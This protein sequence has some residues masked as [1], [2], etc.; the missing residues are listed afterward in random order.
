MVMNL[1]KYP[2]NINKNY[3]KLKNYANRGMTLEHEINVTNK[4]Y[5]ENNIAV[6]HKKPTPIQVVKQIGGKIT[7]AYFMSPSTT[8][9][10]GIYMSNYVDFEAKETTS[11]TSFPLSN[12][13]PHQIK[14]LKDVLTQKGICFLIVRFTSLDETYLLFAKD[15]I[16]YIEKENKKSIPLNYFKEKGHIIETKIMPRVD[17]LN[18]IKKYGGKNNE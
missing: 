1:I 16:N 5:L 4:Y 14:H 3:K 12:I 18:I 17:Y 10:N 9:Y 13:H 8:D 2:N 11:K 7:D 6:I 15:F